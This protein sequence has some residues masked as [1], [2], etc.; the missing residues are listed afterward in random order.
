M[1]PARQSEKCAA[2]TAPP[3]V[4]E[5]PPATG[6]AASPIQARTASM[7]S[8]APDAPGDPS[9]AEAAFEADRPIKAGVGHSRVDREA[10][11]P[12]LEQA[13]QRWMHRA[14]DR[15]RAPECTRP[16]RRA[17]AE[18]GAFRTRRQPWPCAECGDAAARRQREA[19]GANPGGIREH[20]AGHTGNDR[21]QQSERR[22][23]C[24]RCCKPPP[25]QKIRSFTGTRVRSDRFYEVQRPG[26][27]SGT[28]TP[29]ASVSS[30]VGQA[31]SVNGS[32]RQLQ[33]FTVMA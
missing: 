5:T 19:D 22:V 24:G 10:A 21:D 31:V 14:L 1:R 7:V 12:R 33:P 3:T 18:H 8:T 6:S 9:R 26:S 15:R 27:N 13:A 25:T 17:R 16:R 28:G 29:P 11:N 30:D 2:S 32:K 20:A 23:A 4:R